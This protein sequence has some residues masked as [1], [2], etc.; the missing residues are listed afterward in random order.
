M[1]R[2]CVRVLCTRPAHLP[3]WDVV[4]SPQE[5]RAT[6]WQQQQGL[7]KTRLSTLRHA[8]RGLSRRAGN[9]ATHHVLSGCQKR[10]ARLGLASFA[11]SPCGLRMV[12][13]EGC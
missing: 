3:L 12:T 6:W 5:K 10:A 11:L 13:S 2:Q 1:A 4:P 8:I 9:T 7:H